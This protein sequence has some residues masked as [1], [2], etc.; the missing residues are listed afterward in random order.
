MYIFLVVYKYCLSCFLRYNLSIKRILITWKKLSFSHNQYTFAAKPK[1]EQIYTTNKRTDKYNLWHT[2]CWA[3]IKSNERP[4][5]SQ[6][7]QIKYGNMVNVVAE[8]AG[9]ILLIII[10]II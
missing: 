10:I 4:C 1:N 6:K 2:E 5:K 3:D 9:Y 7:L 8:Y